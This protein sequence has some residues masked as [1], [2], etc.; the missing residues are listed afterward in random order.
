MP[1]HPAPAFDRRPTV[2]AADLTAVNENPAEFEAIYRAYIQ[3]VFRYLCN[4]VGDRQEAEELTAQTFLAVMERLPAYKHNGHFPA[5]LFSIARHKA[6]DYFRRLGRHPDADLA[7][8]LPQPSA[9][10][11]SGFDDTELR[12]LSTLITSLPE[13]DQEL[14]RLRYV[15]E[16]SFAEI[17]ALQGRKIDAVKK[18]LY[19]LLARLQKQM[20]AADE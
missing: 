7:E 9:E 4:R 19:R 2:D 12:N 1:N 17:S 10:N 6:A 15:A 11:Q 20:E 3:P 18:T 14:L 5:W 13:D 8:D 16:L